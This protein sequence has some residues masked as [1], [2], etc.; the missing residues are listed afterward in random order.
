MQSKTEIIVKQVV[1]VFFCIFKTSVSVRFIH[2][3]A[4]ILWIGVPNVSQV[5]RDL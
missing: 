4:R 3:K 2:P 1:A 5:G